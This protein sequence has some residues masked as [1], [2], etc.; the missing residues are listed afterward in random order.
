MHAEFKKYSLKFRSPVKFFG[1]TLTERSGFLLRLSYKSRIV[2]GEIPFFPTMPQ[3]E[4][5]RNIASVKEYLS[6]ENLNLPVPPR[7]NVSFAFGLSS[8][9]LALRYDVDLDIL[10]VKSYPFYQSISDCTSRGSFPKVKFSGSDSEISA[11][12][13][14]EGEKFRLDFNRRLS[15]DEACK[16][17]TAIDL[18][19]ILYI[20]EPISDIKL[21][22]ELKRRFDFSLA[23]DETIINREL[24]PEMLNLADYLIIKPALIGNFDYIAQLVASG[25]KIVFSSAYESKIGT[26]AIRRLICFHRLERFTHG[27]DT[28]KYIEK[29]EV[30]P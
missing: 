28:E 6:K 17:L 29:C 12:N 14:A 16:L 25:K 4:V 20:E 2:E 3:N 1:Q 23:L 30:E 9:L 26:D 5:E 15:F 19:N 13:S 27:L 21:L 8:C 22:P 18:N 10:R 11:I 7:L 24:T